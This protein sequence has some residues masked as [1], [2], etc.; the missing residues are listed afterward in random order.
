MKKFIIVIFIL[1]LI[2]LIYANDF[3]Y[4]KLSETN[5]SGCYDTFG[6]P[7]NNYPY[8]YFGS[9][10]GLQTFLIRDNGDLER[11]STLLIEGELRH[12]V[13]K[14]NFIY[15]SAWFIENDS[16]ALYKISISNPAQPQIVLTK[17]SE[18][19]KY[20]FLS[21]VC[22]NL[23]LLNNGIMTFIDDSSMDD[24]AEI[25]LHNFPNCFEISDSLFALYDVHDPVNHLDI[26][27]VYN[28]ENITNIHVSNHLYFPI[29]ENEFWCS[30]E[31][32]KIGENLYAELGIQSITFYNISDS[33]SVSQISHLILPGEGYSKYGYCIKKNNYI[34]I[35]G[36]MWIDIVN[37]EDI[38]DPIFVERKCFSDEILSFFPTPITNT[39]EYLYMGTASKGILKMSFDND[40][41]EFLGF[42]LDNDFGYPNYS[43]HNDKLFIPSWNGG[44]AIFDLSDP[45]NP[46]FE[47][48]IFSNKLIRDK[49]SFTDDNKIIFPFRYSQGE[50]YLAKY[51]ISDL[52]NPILLYQVSINYDRFWKVANPNEPNNIVYLLQENN[53]QSGITISKYDFSSDESGD[54]LFSYTKDETGFFYNLDGFFKSNKFYLFNCYLNL[55]PYVFSGF[56]ENNPQ[57]L[58]QV[59]GINSNNLTIVASKYSEPYFEY[60]TT[61]SINTIHYY[62]IDNLDSQELFTT[63]TRG[64]EPYSI[65]DNGMLLARGSYSLNVFD[66][67]NNPS[68]VLDKNSMIKLNSDSPTFTV[69]ERNGIKYLYVIQAECISVYSYDITA[70]GNININPLNDYAMKNY[71]NPFNPT[72]T[73]SFDLPKSA[74]VDLSIYNIKG[75]KVKTLTDEKYSKGKHSL[76]WNGTNDKNQN[77]G[78]GVYFYKLNVNGKIKS[79]K[80]CMMVK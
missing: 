11:I 74:N 44:I 69:F 15:I 30:S 14:D 64:Y 35:P 72:T 43:I 32:K 17:N 20:E 49:I 68:G 34:L 65:I 75:Q 73:I 77:V 4:E 38:A 31:F 55:R 80:K 23:Y 18:N 1:S 26:Y 53:G 28:I 22:N 33:L 70:N 52:E 51:D 8:I 25:Q 66:I 48:K 71:P 58:G 5:I 6:T 47:A 63:K 39:G 36:T 41:L 2:A 67:H 24:I 3:S 40:E 37:I 19:D 79:V 7:I 76:I 61:N 13:R 27:A 29:Q 50:K 46:I 21:K 54:L 56:A 16:S 57:P 45:A 10:Y 12:I 9:R 42:H 78:S 62:N 59:E 60:I